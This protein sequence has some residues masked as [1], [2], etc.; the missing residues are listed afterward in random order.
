MFN[1]LFF[2]LLGLLLTAALFERFRFQTLVP[3]LITL[4]AVLV[5]ALILA[6]A[7][8]WVVVGLVGLM[9][10]GCFPLVYPRV[11]KRFLL[12]PFTRRARR[13]AG[14]RAD[15]RAWFDEEHPA[16]DDEGTQARESFLAYLN[17]GR[18]ERRFIVPKTEAPLRRD[19]D[20]R[21][22]T[23]GPRLCRFWSQAPVAE[24]G[25]FIR[26]EG[27]ANLENGVSSYALFR[28]LTHLAIQD[29]QL[30][31]TV[32]NM[33]NG[34]ATLLAT[35]GTPAQKNRFLTRITRQM[36]TAHL[37]APDLSTA[38][39]LHAHV[40]K[41]E[42]K[43][44][45]VTGLWLEPGWMPLRVLPVRPDLCGL[46]LPIKDVHHVLVDQ[47]RADVCILAPAKLLH[48][49]GLMQPLGEDARPAQA[50]FVR[51]DQVMVLTAKDLQHV[52]YGRCGIRDDALLLAR[53]LQLIQFGGCLVAAQMRFDND[54]EPPLRAFAD[55]R[56]LVYS[57]DASQRFACEHR[58]VS[59]SPFEANEVPR[60]V[61]NRAKRELMQV[62]PI[63]AKNR[64]DVRPASP[65][66]FVPLGE[67][68]LRSFWTVFLEEE[69]QDQ[70][71]R[72]DRMLSALLSRWGQGIIRSFGLGIS[73]GLIAAQARGAS[74][75]ALAHLT[76]V[77]GC[78]F[79]TQILLDL[80]RGAQDR[81]E[82][83]TRA[84]HR[85]AHAYSML[86]HADMHQLQLWHPGSTVRTLMDWVDHMTMPR[87]LRIVFKWMVLP[88]G[89]IYGAI[90]PSEHRQTGEPMIIPTSERAQLLQPFAENLASFAVTEELCKLAWA[91]KDLCETHALDDTSDQKHWYERLLK[92][93]QISADEAQ[94]LR[95]FY[96]IHQEVLKIY[97][98][99]FI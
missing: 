32:F 68:Q 41:N 77:F 56:R 98:K 89:N 63:L 61:F 22:R 59:H 18:F 87:G 34:L 60:R 53:T 47:E 29:S 95:R 23:R 25:R 2:V 69:D 1:F 64:T 31:E 3:L 28:L 26:Q 99:A 37:V 88:L 92:T 66:C 15:E 94:L 11:R 50:C 38:C 75:R 90:Q 93:K 40:G 62:L 16:S 84:Y 39:G 27:F 45:E 19:E 86:M 81:P 42:V 21:L 35:R 4:A 74:S 30:A 57:L 44:Q 9:L 65:A 13:F 49:H 76:A 8:F 55:L 36:I 73:C 82:P 78:L 54:L 43:G 70:Q 12:V 79:D 33:N 24:R 80:W 72:A 52:V 14:A 96:D 91:V 17:A 58:D 7:P 51:L 20:E 5:L 97:V 46:C 48:E 67:A 83:C 71:M 6:G 10:I 85:L